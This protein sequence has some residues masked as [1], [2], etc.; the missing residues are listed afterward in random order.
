MIESGN[1]QVFNRGE[2]VAWL[3]REDIEPKDGKV[4]EIMSL[5]INNK[6]AY[7]VYMF[8]LDYAVI[9]TKEMANILKGCL[10]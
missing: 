7:A 3:K 4:L 6:V 1:I 8:D 9:V 10:R 5:S 2:Q